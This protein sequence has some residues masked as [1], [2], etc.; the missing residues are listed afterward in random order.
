[1]RS[2]CRWPSLWTVF[3][4][5]CSFQQ[6]S[7]VPLIN[8]PWKKKQFQLSAGWRG[9]SEQSMWGA[10]VKE[11]AAAAGLGDV[12]EGENLSMNPTTYPTQAAERTEEKF[13]ISTS[14]TI[15]SPFYVAHSRRVYHS[16]TPPRCSVEMVVCVDIPWTPVRLSYK[17]WRRNS[18]SHMIRTQYRSTVVKYCFQYVDCDCEWLWLHSAFFIK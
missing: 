17:H 14:T 8:L 2:V 1:M 6:P 7:S 13:H 4:F 15:N 18:I 10:S 16:N 12:G 5:I 11:A 3:L 9:I